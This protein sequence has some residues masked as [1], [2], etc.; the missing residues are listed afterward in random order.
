MNT[1]QET[2]QEVE[3]SEISDDELTSSVTVESGVSVSADGLQAALNES[4][5]EASVTDFK[6]GTCGLT[7]GHGTN[8]HRATD[9]FDI[10]MSDIDKMDYNPNCHC[11]VNEL[12]RHGSDFGVDESAAS[13]TANSAPIP[14]DTRQEM[15]AEYGGA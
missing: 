6:C 1:V 14:D 10:S 13:R 7:H 9:S 5:S 3:Q 15:N 2:I 12:A 11:G 4:A 8:K